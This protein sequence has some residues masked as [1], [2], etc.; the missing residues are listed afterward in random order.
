MSN[1]YVS[2]SGAGYFKNVSEVMLGE[3]NEIMLRK[4]QLYNLIG[5]NPRV[6]MENNHRNH[7][8]FMGALFTTNDYGM[9]EKTIPWILN[10]Y[11]SKGFSISY[12]SHVLKSWKDVIK[13]HI[14]VEYQN[15][16]LPVYDYMLDAIENSRIMRE[17][18]EISTD[19]TVL[20]LSEMLVR[21]DYQEASRYLRCF[22]KDQDSLFNAYL[23]IIQPTMYTIGAMWEKDEISVAHEHLATSIIMRIMSSFYDQYVLRTPDKYKILIAAAVNEFHEIGARIVSDYLEIN[24]YDVRFLGSNMPSDDLV[25]IL[26]KEK[27]RVLGL[28][29]SMSYNIGKLIETVQEIRSNKD[30]AEIRIMAGGYAFSYADKSK[31]AEFNVIVPQNLSDMIDTCAKWQ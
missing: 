25:R 18:V 26:L 27:P 2:P 14:P 6:V 16:I 29:V 5:P 13:K 8:T 3:V 20:A 31:L 28:S 1:L 19:Q 4:N 9:L 10:T 12:F 30:L 22:I 21:G 15:E 7:V 24:G 11:L 23:N 17:S